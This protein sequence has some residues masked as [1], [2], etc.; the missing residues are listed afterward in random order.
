MSWN[1]DV[2]AQSLMLFQACVGTLLHK[3][4]GYLVRARWWWCFA[5]VRGGGKLGL[6][7]CRLGR[8]GCG[9][10][11]P[12]Q[13]EGVNGFVL[14]SFARPDNA[15]RWAMQCVADLKRA[16]WCVC[17]TAKVSRLLLCAPNRARHGEPLLW[18]GLSCRA[19]AGG[20][21]EPRA[22]RGDGDAQHRPGH[23]R[24]GGEC[25]H[26]R[27]AHQGGSRLRAA[28]R[29]DQ[30]RHR[31]HELPRPLHEPRRAHRRRRRNRAGACE[32]LDVG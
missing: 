23:R 10:R 32:V 22:G 7:T 1:P 11:R 17:A 12:A 16:D 19:Q 8:H 14:A 24:H 2:A 13:V 25:H 29:R 18:A 21:A 28:A 31:P 9:A 3:H 5:A 20:A 6:W 30:L 26:A 27:P 15:V 4:G